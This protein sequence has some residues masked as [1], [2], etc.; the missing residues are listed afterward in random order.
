MHAPA[1]DQEIAT[2]FDRSAGALVLNFG[3]GRF[4]HGTL[5]VIRSLGRLGI[6]VFAIQLR[7]RLPISFT[8]Y[9]SGTF[10][11][12]TRSDRADDFLEGLGKIAKVL[13]RPS[14]LIPSDDLSAI[15]IAENA[16]QIPAQFIATRQIAQL[17]RMLANKRTLWHFCQQRGVEVPP[18]FFPTSETELFELSGNLQYPVIVK[19]AEPWLLPAGFRSVVMIDE[20]RDLIEYYNAFTQYSTAASLMIQEMISGSDCEDWFVHGYFDVNSKP[21]VLFTGIKLRSYPAFAGATTLGRAVRNETLREQAIKLCSDIGYSGIVDLDFRLDKNRKYHLLDFNP[22]VGAQFSL[23]RTTTGMDVVRALHL[24]L[25]GRPA[26]P[27]QQIEGRTFLSEVQDVVASYKYCRKGRLSVSEWVRSV[28][29]IDEHAWYASDDLGPFFM[30]CWSVLGRASARL[31]ETL[32]RIFKPK[33]HVN[34]C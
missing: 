12:S 27:G 1:T 3:K 15:L 14:I 18:T 29:N 9:L 7:P 13:D 33:K 23:F 32:T 20:S 24:D 16:N 21:V 5:A 31:G 10:S 25:T 6:P 4:L 26:H 19:V 2:L 30:M 17:P 22:R 34:V 8:R 11:W 28:R